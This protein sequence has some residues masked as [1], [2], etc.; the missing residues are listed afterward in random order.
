MQESCEKYKTLITGL[1]D[2][3][4][5]DNKKQSVKAHLD[6]CPGCHRI[7]VAES[8]IKKL[9]QQRCEMKSAPDYLKT[10]VRHNLQRRG[11]RP[12]FW[13][14]TKSMFEYR[15]VASSFAVAFVVIMMFTSLFYANL[16][17]TSADVINAGI[18]SAV[19]NGEII[20][21]DCEHMPTGLMPS[22]QDMMMHRLGIRAEDATVWTFLYSGVAKELM[23]D[24]QFLKQRI[25][26]KGTLFHESHY[27]Q[28]K[29]YTLL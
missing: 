9:V 26:V 12:G 7:F 10:R 24:H 15:P 14:L 16:T 20:C 8:N 6:D 25:S 2:D 27:M 19:L 3:E 18:V 23:G 22:K 17:D 1:V 5:D 4:L 13:Q 28:V 29:E 21:L 11:S